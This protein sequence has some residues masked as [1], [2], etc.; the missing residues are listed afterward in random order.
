MCNSASFGQ[1]SM[2]ASNNLSEMFEEF[3]MKEK[4]IQEEGSY[5]PG[6]AEER[7][8]PIF[9][10]KINLAAEDFQKVAEGNDP[11]QEKYLNAIDLGLDR[12][13]DVYLELDTEDRERVCLYFEELM[14]IVGLESSGGRLN[15]FVYGF[16]PSEE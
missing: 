5:Y 13:S 7:L 11:T 14:E 1:V 9:S 12:F 8:R 4:F 6:I 15:K 10:K 3:K 16:N 2:T